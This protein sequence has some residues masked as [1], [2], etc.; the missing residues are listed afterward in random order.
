MV[1]AP[2]FSMGIWQDD[3]QGSFLT[4]TILWFQLS[5]TNAYLIFTEFLFRKLEQL[6]I[7][8]YYSIGLL[9]SYQLRFPISTGKRNGQS[10]RK[11]KSQLK[12]DVCC[13]FAMSFHLGVS[14]LPLL[15]ISVLVPQI[16]ASLSY[17]SILP[18]FWGHHEDQSSKKDCRHVGIAFF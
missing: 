5:L 16:K 7:R 11:R 3:L 17:H 1:P 15:L 13:F 18:E 14:S 10:C 12:I 8:K 9:L 2:C 4:S 6:L